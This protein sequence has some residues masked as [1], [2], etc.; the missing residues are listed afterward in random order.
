MHVFSWLIQVN[1]S[2][3]FEADTEGVLDSSPINLQERRSWSY[4]ESSS[5]KATLPRGLLDIL[6]FPLP[7]YFL[8]MLPVVAA[9]PSYYLVTPKH[10]ECLLIAIIP[11]LKYERDR[12]TSSMC[13][14]KHRNTKSS[15]WGNMSAHIT[16]NLLVAQ[17]RREMITNSLGY[18]FCKPW[19]SL[20]DAQMLYKIVIT[21]LLVKLEGGKVS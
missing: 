7:T 11:N 9:F 14:S 5:R 15:Y 20:V 1:K 13:V 18:I 8:H 17:E 12:H 16:Q 4:R 21:D 10:W 19:L 3:L 2:H 6:L